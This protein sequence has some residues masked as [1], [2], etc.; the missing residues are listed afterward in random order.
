MA[1][2]M[3]LDPK[4]CDVI[5]RRYLKEDGVAPS[6]VYV[7]RDGRRMSLEEALEQAGAVL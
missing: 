6:D 2:L 5:I 3:E 4:Y 1:R 7:E